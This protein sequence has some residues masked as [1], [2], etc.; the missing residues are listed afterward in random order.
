MFWVLAVLCVQ[1]AQGETVRS[2][3]ILKVSGALLA[4]SKT[5]KGL[6]NGLGSSSLD[7]ADKKSKVCHTQTQTQVSANNCG[8]MA[9]LGFPPF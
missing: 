4:F 3:K 2:F 6:H 9:S 8:Q 1:M 5:A 7:F